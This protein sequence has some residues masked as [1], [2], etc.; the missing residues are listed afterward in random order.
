VQSKSLDNIYGGQLPKRVVIGFVENKSFNGDYKRNPFNFQHFNLTSIS[1]VKNG[2]QIPSRPIECD[3]S[4]GGHFITAYNTLLTG[5]GI[6]FLNQD[7]GFSRND[8][9]KGNTLF[10]FDLTPDLSASCD[11]HWQLKDIGTL[12]LELRFSAALAD[13]INCIFYAEFD[14]L[15]EISKDREVT[16][17]Y[18]C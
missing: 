1:L 11:T 6:N 15:I 17:D 8:Y 10:L 18:S 2:K 14:N 3:F 4:D 16:V 5:T 7:I 12:G 13:T 9:A